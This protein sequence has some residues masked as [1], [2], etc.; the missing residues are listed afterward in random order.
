MKYEIDTVRRLLIREV[1]KPAPSPILI[2]QYTAL[3]QTLLAQAGDLSLSDAD[4][5]SNFLMA[6]ENTGII[7]IGGNGGRNYKRVRESEG[8]RL[9]AVIGDLVAQNKPDPL[10]SLLHALP[11]LRTLYTPEQWASV[12]AQVQSA[13]SIRLRE[14]SGDV[15]TA[16]A[17][18]AQDPVLYAK[19]CTVD[20]N[21]LCTEDG[22]E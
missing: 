6:D 13:V 21:T 3:L 4:M 20:D 5:D 18:M 15:V 16:P 22:G 11:A 12:Q 7:N 17:T 14:V 1:K 2:K 10:N 8:D 9:L 19:C